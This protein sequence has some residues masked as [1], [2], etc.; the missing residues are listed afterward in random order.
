M[1]IHYHS[2]A[3]SVSRRRKLAHRSAWRLESRPTASLTGRQAG[4][5]ALQQTVGNRAAAQFVQTQR[6]PAVQRKHILAT[7]RSAAE[8]ALRDTYDPNLKI[9]WFG[10]ETTADEF[11]ETYVLLVSGRANG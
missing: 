3:G 11:W 7:E 4:V 6:P 9:T 2:L 10:S 5:M 8:T 1:A